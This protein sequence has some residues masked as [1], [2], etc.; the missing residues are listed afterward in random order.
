MWVIAVVGAAPCQ[1]FSPGENQTTSPGRISSIGPPQRWARPTPD[2]TIGVWPSGWVCHAVRARG[3][4][5][6]L[7]PA[8]RA[9]T[10]ASNNGSM[11]TVPVNQ[12]AG[13]F[14]EACEP[15]RLI[16]ISPPG[17]AAETRTNENVRVASAVRKTDRREH[18][19]RRFVVV[20]LVMTD[21]LVDL[22]LPSPH[23]VA[24][25]EELTLPASFGKLVLGKYDSNTV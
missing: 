10:G 11:R 5:V 9:G 16:S 8:A 1:C 14:A 19:A 18:P 4:N 15:L 2:V 7:A 13:P 3:S 12:S 17:V 22:L 23:H 21:R 25:M 24:S 6:T 20:S